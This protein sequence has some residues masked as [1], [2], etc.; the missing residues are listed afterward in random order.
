MYGK[1]AFGLCIASPSMSYASSE[2]E[3]NGKYI[4]LNDGHFEVE[5]YTIEMRKTLIVFYSSQYTDEGGEERDSMGVVNRITDL[6]SQLESKYSQ[7]G[8]VDYLAIGTDSDFT[9]LENEMNKLRN[10]SLE[11]MREDRDELTAFVINVYNVLIRVA[12]VIAGIPKSD[13]SRLSFFDT[14]AVNVG[15]DIYTFNDMENGILR[16]NSVPPYHLAK[17]FPK[18]DRRESLALSSVDPRIHFALNCGAKSC[19]PVKQYTAKGLNDELQ[20]SAIEFC[21][22]KSNVSIDE[23]RGELRLSKIFKW[24]MNDFASSR[25]VLPKQVSKY[26]IG[27]DQDSLDRLLRKGNVKTE[28]LNYDWTTND[29]NSKR[30]G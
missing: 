7:N 5:A 14:V 10:I 18:G 19:P 23:E 17:P 30:F 26:L 29:T 13:L 11:N 21:Q 8:L 27:M 20:V 28:F 1:S 22:N 12:F 25:G 3:T 2:K 4:V 15:G 9:K 16:A 24:Y 6:W